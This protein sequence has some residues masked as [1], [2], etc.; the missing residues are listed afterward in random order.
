[1]IE[2]VHNWKQKGYERLEHPFKSFADQLAIRLANLGF[3]GYM[4][5]S[6]KGVREGLI[7]YIKKTCE[8]SE[9]LTVTQMENRDENIGTNVWKEIDINGD[10]VN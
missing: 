8:N 10:I 2:G 7:K 4:S 6:G 3:N 1:L 9:R 5:C